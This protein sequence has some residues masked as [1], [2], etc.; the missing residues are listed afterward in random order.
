MSVGFGEKLKNTNQ[1]KDSI[2]KNVMDAV[3]SQISSSPFE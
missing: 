3:E 1:E 2:P